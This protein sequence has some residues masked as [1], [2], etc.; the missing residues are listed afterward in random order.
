[1]LILVAAAWGMRVM[2]NLLKKTWTIKIRTAFLLQVKESQNLRSW[3][4]FLA[5]KQGKEGNVSNF[6][7]LK[8][9]TGN[10]SDSMT[11]STESGDQNL[12]CSN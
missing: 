7:D 11:R 4:F 3:S 2:H 1:M 6:D 9:D 12:N 10:I 5:S 8:S